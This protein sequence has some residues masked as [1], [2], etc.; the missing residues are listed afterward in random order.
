MENKRQKI[1]IRGNNKKVDKSRDSYA[2]AI[3][4]VVENPSNLPSTKRTLH[5][6]K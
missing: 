4:P 2:E 5:V 6:Y 3:R 1:I